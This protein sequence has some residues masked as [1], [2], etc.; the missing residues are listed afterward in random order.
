MTEEIFSIIVS[1]MA[2][3]ST[4]I[5]GQAQQRG[6]GRKQGKKNLPNLANQERFIG[7]L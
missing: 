7:Q 3:Y 1:V 4:C 6:R 2:T 5:P